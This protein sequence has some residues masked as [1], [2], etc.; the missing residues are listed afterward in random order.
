M[1]VIYLAYGQLAD[2]PLVLLANRDEFYD[3]PTLP[4]ASWEDHPHVFGGRDLAAGGTW[5]AVSNSG[6][7]A[8]V[9]NYRDPGGQLGTRS[10][11]KLVSDFVSGVSG[12]REYLSEIESRKAEYSG[13]NLLVGEFREDRSELLYFSNRSNGIRELSP[14]LYGLSNHLLDSQWP[15][16][17][18][19][20]AMLSEILGQGLESEA[21]FDLLGDRELA[22]DEELPDTG[23]G[24]E[25]E[26]ALSPIFI[27]TPNYG[28]RCSTVV[29]ADHRG[30]FEFEERVFV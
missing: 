8:A 14:G 6:R 2:T 22:R 17:T 5:L 24:L 15:K 30:R 11:G 25:R 16:V 7:I 9:T 18:K 29:I 21:M 4:A 12:A 27:A 23:I 1:C 3:R 13:F 19:G 10:R 26:R 20:K 28:T